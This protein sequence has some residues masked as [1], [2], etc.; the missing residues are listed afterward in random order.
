LLLDPATRLSFLHSEVEV[1]KQLENQ[2]V[3]VELD[4]LEVVVEVWMIE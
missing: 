3:V 1:V 2:V 4:L